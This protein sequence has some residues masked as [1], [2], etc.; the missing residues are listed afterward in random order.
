MQK[1]PPE[2]TPIRLLIKELPKLS[3]LGH[4]R[5]RDNPRQAQTKPITIQ[6]P[7]ESHFS[8]PRLKNSGWEREKPARPTWPRSTYTLHSLTIN[9]SQISVGPFL[10]R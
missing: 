4:T 7:N 10:P 5:P 8:P 6:H 2:C 3:N 9:Y 1:S